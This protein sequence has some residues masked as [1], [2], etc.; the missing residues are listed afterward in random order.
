MLHRGLVSVL[1]HV[2]QFVQECYT[3]RTR[4]WASVVREIE[5]FRCLMV[6]GVKDMMSTWSEQIFCTD[7][8]LS[9]YAV[10]SRQLPLTQGNGTEI[11]G[12]F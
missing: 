1:R 9:G 11:L 5:L 8:C 4:L 2:Y 3:S 6:L 7:A 12:C 10:M